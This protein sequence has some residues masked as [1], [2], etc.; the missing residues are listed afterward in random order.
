MHT[1]GPWKKTA[2]SADWRAPCR[3]DS[4][5]SEAR[6]IVGPDGNAVAMS[7]ASYYAWTDRE[8]SQ[9]CTANARLIA[10]APELHA[11]ALR[12][13]RLKRDAGEVGAGMLAPL[14]DE[15]RRLTDES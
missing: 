10:K 11:L 13:A 1:P 5:T 14:V 8:K 2:F 7:V 12:I 3:E 9:E 4:E 6:M 15:A